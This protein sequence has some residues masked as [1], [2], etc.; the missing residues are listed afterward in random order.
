MAEIII[1]FTAAARL[2]RASL[3][4]PQRATGRQY[5]AAGVGTITVLS[6][7]PSPPERCRVLAFPPADR[8][9]RSM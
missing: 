3:R 8:G 5:G 1:Y 2:R 6:G 9:G 7:F 4:L